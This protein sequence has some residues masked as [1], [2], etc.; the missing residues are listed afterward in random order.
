VWTASI[1]DV[2]ISNENK[3]RSPLIRLITPMRRPCRLTA[4]A[5][6]VFGSK[7]I[8]VFLAGL[9]VFLVQRIERLLC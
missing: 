6:S 9:V 2:A 8:M 3:Y 4:S 5:F 7:F 1:L